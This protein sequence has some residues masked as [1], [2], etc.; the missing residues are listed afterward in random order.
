M[1]LIQNIYSEQAENYNWLHV[2]CIGC[3]K[4][5][6]NIVLS[7]KSGGQEFSEQ[8]LGKFK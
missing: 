1:F 2:I 6:D 7:E 3:I 4:S 8:P 5:S